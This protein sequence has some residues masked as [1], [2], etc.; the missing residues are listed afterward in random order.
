[1]ESLLL[2]APAEVALIVYPVYAHSL[3]RSLASWVRPVQALAQVK[4][5]C[6]PKYPFLQTRELGLTHFLSTASRQPQ[7]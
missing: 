7:N 5:L 3:T 2:K 4:K 6:L 1:M